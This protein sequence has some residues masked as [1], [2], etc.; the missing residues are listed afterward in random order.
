MEE[1]ARATI[2][3]ILRLLGKFI[4]LIT[5]VNKKKPFRS[6]KNEKLVMIAFKTLHC[7]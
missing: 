5:V 6:V 4:I 2:A 3:R 7:Q 1:S